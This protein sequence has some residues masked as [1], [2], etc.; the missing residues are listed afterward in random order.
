MGGWAG[1]L[2]GRSASAGGGAEK[3]KSSAIIAEAQRELDEA[4][5]H[6]RGRLVRLASLT[7]VPVE[8]AWMPGVCSD[9]A[10]QRAGGAD[11][12]GLDVGQE[13]V[14]RAARI[15]EAEIAP[16]VRSAPS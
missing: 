16:T 5:V 6:A 8:A 2:F 3:E 7:L 14:M 11:R 1:A 13:H 9:E 12:D 10:V 4:S 15:R